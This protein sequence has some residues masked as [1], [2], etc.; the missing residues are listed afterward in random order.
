MAGSPFTSDYFTKKINE[1]KLPLNSEYIQIINTEFRKLQNEKASFEDY[2]EVVDKNI[3]QFLKEKPVPE[4]KTSEEEPNPENVPVESARDIDLNK[5]N[6][7]L[8]TLNKEG[9]SVTQEQKNNLI[10]EINTILELPSKNKIISE[11]LLKAD[12]PLS[13]PL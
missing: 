13:I 1:V 8:K 12:C 4:E 2:K 11:G 7:Y 3:E 5:L 10:E 6:D 9:V